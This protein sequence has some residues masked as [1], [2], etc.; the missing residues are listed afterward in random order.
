MTSLQLHGHG[1]PHPRHRRA[2]R[3]RGRSRRGHR[4]IAPAA[5][6]IALFSERLDHEREYESTLRDFVELHDLAHAADVYDS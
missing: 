4:L 5:D 3:H 2:T 6:D 1:R